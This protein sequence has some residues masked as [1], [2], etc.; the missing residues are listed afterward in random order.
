M[1]QRR[2]EEEDQ[3][4]VGEKETWQSREGGIAKRQRSDNRES[5]SVGKDFGRKTEGKGERTL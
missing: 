2:S 1:K 3:K 4:I 5:S